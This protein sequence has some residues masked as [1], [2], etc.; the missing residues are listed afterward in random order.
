MYFY[1][2]MWRQMAIILT[3]SWQ[4]YPYVRN[5][6]LSRTEKTGINKILVLIGGRIV[7]II[8]LSDDKA[9]RFASFPENELNEFIIVFD[10]V[11]EIKYFELFCILLNCFV[12]YNKIKKIEVITYIIVQCRI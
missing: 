11:N 6:T 2:L 7:L 10:S 12:R 9:S 5:V 8:H 4:Y 1:S 3:V